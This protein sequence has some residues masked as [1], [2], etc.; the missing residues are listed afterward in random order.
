MELLLR[1]LPLILLSHL[2]E[3]KQKDFYTFKVVNSRG[4]LV[5]LEKYRGSVSRLA[6]LL[7]GRTDS[8]TN[9]ARS[10]DAGNRKQTVLSVDLFTLHHFSGFPEHARCW[11]ARL[12]G[13]NKVLTWKYY[14]LSSSGAFFRAARAYVA[15]LFSRAAARA[16]S[17]DMEFI[18][19][20]CTSTVSLC[21]LARALKQYLHFVILP[22]FCLHF[23]FFVIKASR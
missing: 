10:H 7:C 4:R 1:A 9:G 15:N 21:T 12:L 19:N 18:H 6:L 13:S 16:W 22:N 20:V 2:M 3:A 11:S 5:S 23:C 17:R 14:G 8:L